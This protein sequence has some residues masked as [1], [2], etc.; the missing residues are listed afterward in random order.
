MAN[1]SCLLSPPSPS[2]TVGVNLTE[3]DMLLDMPIDSSWL[4]R[5]RKLS[6]FSP[7]GPNALLQNGGR[8]NFFIVV[9]VQ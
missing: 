2:L 9:E 3:F 8:H 5:G 6:R 7:T 4:L 1:Q